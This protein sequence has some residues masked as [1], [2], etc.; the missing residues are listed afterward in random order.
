MHRLKQ[1]HQSKMKSTEYES[2]VAVH[3]HINHALFEDAAQSCLQINESNQHITWHRLML[4]HAHRSIL[5]RQQDARV[6]RTSIEVKKKKRCKQNH[7]TN[8]QRTSIF[9]Q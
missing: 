7:A 9:K 5:F 4:F 2:K 3:M 8:Q 6:Q 1:Q